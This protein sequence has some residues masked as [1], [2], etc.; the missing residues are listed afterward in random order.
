MAISYTLDVGSVNK[1]VTHGSFE[2]V[3]IEA[4]FHVFA[5]SDEIT[6]GSEEEGNYTVTRPAFS[7]CESGSIALSTD[8]LEEGSFIAFDSVSKD[9]LKDW[10][11]ASEG[12]SEVADFSYVK[13]A[14]EVVAK[15]IYEYN[16]Q[17]PDVVAGT[18]S[19]SDLTG[20]SD[21]VY[22]PPSE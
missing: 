3:I 11:L 19:D 7:H 17:V 18:S 6:T 22:T 5:I 1:K 14:I 16:P 12:V 4:F 20:T 9:T 10:I 21:Y 2:N 15:E 13:S 8:S